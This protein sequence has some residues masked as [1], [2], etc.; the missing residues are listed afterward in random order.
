MS[1]QV[2][3]GSLLIVKKAAIFWKV[4]KREFSIEGK[5]QQRAVCITL[6]DADNVSGTALGWDLEVQLPKTVHFCDT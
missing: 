4:K 6:S 3:A 1:E 2:C 5:T